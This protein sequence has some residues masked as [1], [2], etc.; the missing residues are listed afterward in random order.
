MYTEMPEDRPATTISCPKKEAWTLMANQLHDHP[1]TGLGGWGGPLLTKKRG[2]C[3]TLILKGAGLSRR[4]VGSAES[5]DCVRGGSSLPPVASPCCAL[6]ASDAAG[7]AYLSSSLN[8]LEL[9]W[10]ALRG[11]SLSARSAKAGMPGRAW[12]PSL[13]GRTPAGEAVR[14]NEVQGVFI[15]DDAGE[16][17]TED[18]NEAG[19]RDARERAVGEPEGDAA[20]GDRVRPAALVIV[21]MGTGR[22]RANSGRALMSFKGA[23]RTAAPLLCC[24]ANW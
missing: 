1:R 20:G 16:D 17:T 13:M 5:C 11:L 8:W 24:G 10:V 6:D 12:T 23:Q 2:R 19:D 14:L 3:E 15:N 18:W 4:G 22:I 9:S 7:S 21:V